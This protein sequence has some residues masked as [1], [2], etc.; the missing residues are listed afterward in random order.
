MTGKIRIGLA[1]AGLILALFTIGWAAEPDPAPHTA[2]APGFEVYSLGEVVVSAPAFPAKDIAIR[3]EVTAEDI[4][5]THSHTV[6]QALSHAPGVNV[7]TGA[8]NQATVS[9][10]GFDQSRVLVLIDGVPY[11]E[12]KFGILDLNSI[13][14]E[15]IAKIEIVKGAASVLYGANAMGGVINIVTKKPAERPY[16]SATFEYSE[17]ATYRASFSHGLKKG[18]F[19]Y[20][21]GYSFEKSD[22]WDLSDDY[23]PKPGTLT[24][25]HTGSPV[26]SNP[27]FE[28]GGTRDNSD[29]EGH[30]FFAKVGIE[31]D[32]DSAYYLNFHYLKK[33]KGVPSNTVSNMVFSR[34]VFSRFYAARIP[35]YDQWGLDFDA[36]QGL[37][38]KLT[39]KAKLFY[40]H[41]KDS[42]YSYEDP[43]FE[44]ILSK[45]H[46]KDYMAGGSLMLDYRPVSWD[47][48]RLAVHYRGDSHQEV[49]D[50]YLP[51]EKYFSY[52]GSVGLENE[53]TWVRN[54]SVIMGVSYDWFEVTDAKKNV[55]AGNGDFIRQEEI[56][57]PSDNSVNPMIGFSYT[58]PDSTRL[59]A[60]VAR[61]SRFPTL[62]NLYNLV[63]NGDPRLE[64]EK[65]INYTLGVSRVFGSMVK[66][67]FSV[68]CHDIEDK[69]SSV[70]IGADKRMVNIG[71]VRMLVYE[72]GLEVYPLDKLILRADYTY[73]HAED[74]SEDRFSDK[75]TD[76]PK[77]LVNL[78]AQYTLPKV[79]TRIDVNGS[80]VGAVYTDVNPGTEHELESYYLCNA[81]LTQGFGKYFEAYVAAKNLFD[82]DYEWGDGYPA[83]GRSFWAGLTARY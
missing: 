47:A 58:F 78:S 75:V 57:E 29:Y 77:H 32:Q 48:I 21:L 12:T 81:K 66:T 44:T 7:T 3:Q 68:F 49:A 79:G 2:P 62:N 67:D 23:K 37:T 17:D 45:S 54:L 26:V 55:T 41:H 63:A 73:N 42:L 46:Y 25:R 16:A 31:P 35:D 1:L 39:A 61:K 74:R 5:A 13:G 65:S 38:D 80:Y 15:N 22:G 19:N 70:G 43:S 10:H 72:I 51:Y 60:S 8:K 20:W 34:P 82:E 71:E 40:H 64:P 52:T 14:T 36:R 27:V 9:M 76:V 69:I 18:I 50:E 6:A 83:P 30:N 56:Y 28:N 4:R 59:F 53:F 24:D 11:Y 33:E